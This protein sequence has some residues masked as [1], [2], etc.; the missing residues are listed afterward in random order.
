MQIKKNIVDVILP[1]YNSSEFIEKTIQS[2]INQTFKSW[3]LI[4]VDDHSNE[5][6][7][8]VI[9]KYKK[10]KKIKIIWLSKNKGAAYC[11][12]L[13]IKNSNSRYVAFID[14]DDIWKKNKLRVQLNFMKKNDS[15][16]SYTFYETFGLKNKNIKT[17]LTYNF[18]NFT[19]DTSI[20]TSTMIVTRKVI[21]NIK[22][23]NTKIC[24]DYFFKCS[25]LKKIPHAHGLGKFLTKYRIRKNS[26]QSNKLKN[27]YWIWKIN[28]KFNKF[29]FYENL[30]SLF[31]IAK[32]SFSRYGLK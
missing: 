19:K 24:E 4:I 27:L 8:K 17:Q 30:I 26:L 29:N 3:K 1:N 15:N 21:K 5:K 23:T 2:V 9:S 25:I 10:N 12:N 11:R 6:T 28:S 16:F 32:S 14:S 31:S 20:A 22:F 7:R 13:A 18:S